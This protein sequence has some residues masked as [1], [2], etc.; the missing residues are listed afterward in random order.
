VI[1]V[2]SSVSG[3]EN[4]HLKLSV[5]WKV[6]SEVTTINEAP[7]D[8]PDGQGTS[9]VCPDSIGTN[10]RISLCDLRGLCERHVYVRL[11]GSAANQRS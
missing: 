4:R 10:K 1:S 5:S 11:R 7:E 9:S 2:S 3:R 8:L 6:G